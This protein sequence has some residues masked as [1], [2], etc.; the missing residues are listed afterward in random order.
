MRFDASY[1]PVAARGR[2]FV[3]SMVDDSVT[4]LDLETGRELWRVVVDGPVRFAP[5]V[6]GG[7]VLFVSDDGH[8]YCVDAETGAMLWK[9]RGAPLDR[10]VL[11]NDRLISMW[12]AR[13]AP[14]ADDKTVYFAAGIWPFMGVFVH[15]VDIASGQCVW[16][17]S[18]SGSDYLVQQHSSPAFAG[19]APQGYLALSDNLV[20][21]S[22][23]MTVPAAFDRATGRFVYYRPGDRELGKDQGGYEVTVGPS[24]YANRGGIHSLVDGVP[25]TTAPITI[26]T[27][28]CAIGI[29]GKH[30]V[31]IG[32]EVVKYVEISVD[33]KGKETKTVKYKLPELWRT[34]LPPDITDLHLLAGS[35]LLASD[36]QSRLCMLNVPDKS[37]D[38]CH[39]LWETRVEG[40]IWRMLVA[41]QHL[42]VVTEQGSVFCFGNT[43]NAPRTPTVRRAGPLRTP[44][45]YAVVDD[46]RKQVEE[47]LNLTAARAGYAVIDQAEDA[48][49]AI[50]LAR[51]TEFHIILLQRDAER[52][53]SLR[54]QLRDAS[55]HA[56]RV[57]VLPGDLSSAHLPPYLAELV[58]VAPRGMAA[59][60]TEH[61]R[62]ICHPLRPYGGTAI[63]AGT[64]AQRGTTGRSGEQSCHRLPAGVNRQLRGLAPPRSSYRCRHLD[65]PEWRRGQYARIDRFSCEDAA[66]T[67]LVWRTLEPGG[68]AASRSRSDA[69]GNWRAVVH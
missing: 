40:R 25:R 13:G 21:V 23:G 14:V 32:T 38:T 30:L 1:E 24:W 48:A 2:L 47:V 9:Y 7:R 29:S 53:D 28:Q 5:L 37:D 33:K 56:D 31:G 52:V 39:V 19:V 6:H 43:D 36:G 10:K 55:L 34:A 12:P 69:T 62:S 68:L 18:G 35:R 26:V 20:L 60:A 51:Q 3:P 16:T 4:A 66:G 67:A 8:L 61:L 58:F 27:P 46:V 65:Q 44:G 22:G 50:G 59:D 11:G 17:N 42:V 57:A 15:A 41:D 45:E 64:T 49:T 54:H 63:I